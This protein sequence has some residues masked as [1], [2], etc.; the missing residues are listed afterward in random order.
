MIIIL[1]IILVL[2]FFIYDDNHPHKQ[3]QKVQLQDF[4]ILTNLKKALQ[5]KEMRTIT[6]L[7][8]FVNLTSSFIFLTL[9]FFIIKRMNLT[10][11]HLSIAIFLIGIAH[12]FQFVFGSISDK[13]G[14]SKGIIIGLAI[15][16]ITFFLMFYSTTYETLLFL[17]LLNAL[18]M[19]L[20]NV[21][22]WSYMSDIGEKYN[23]EGKIIGSYTSIARISVTI[24]HA[25]S[26]VIL[27]LFN[28]QIFYIYA[29]VIIIPLIMLSKTILKYKTD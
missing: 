4:N 20:W 9:P 12:V 10:N 23:I 24:S 16:S 1:L 19:S 28:I 8:S 21:S 15:T 2:D 3:K 11:S 6:I 22:A 13:I 7:G 27:A 29:I 14:K 18:G 26:G 5:Y 17:T 25:L